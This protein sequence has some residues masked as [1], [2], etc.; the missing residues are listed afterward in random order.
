MSLDELEQG[1]HESGLYIA[2]GA[3]TAGTQYLEDILFVLQHTD[4]NADGV[5]NNIGYT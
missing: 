4:L 2:S 1:I 5:I 3:Y